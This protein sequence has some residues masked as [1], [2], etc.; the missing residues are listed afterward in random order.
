MVNRLNRK[1]SYEPCC[2]K[3]EISEK[4]YHLLR[5]L[6]LADKSSSGKK[7]KHS[8]SKPPRRRLILFIRVAVPI[9]WK[10]PPHRHEAAVTLVGDLDAIVTMSAE[11][12]WRESWSL[13]GID[14]TVSRHETPQRSR[15][16]KSFIYRMT[17]SLI[18][19]GYFLNNASIRGEISSGN[20]WD[21]WYSRETGGPSPKW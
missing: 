11:T 18:H 6:M 4:V 1:D 2:S 21:N 16:T 13:V 10:R 3:G 17:D 20:R 8:N 19:R 14:V 9:E 5:I 7:V 15:G 12:E